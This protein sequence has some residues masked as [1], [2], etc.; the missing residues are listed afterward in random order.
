M[1]HEELNIIVVLLHS[2]SGRT[3]LSAW[4]SH[5]HYGVALRSVCGRVAT[6]ALG[7]SQWIKLCPAGALITGATLENGSRERKTPLRDDHLPGSLP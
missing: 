7:A 4:P 1:C 2:L 3:T 5:A 6:G